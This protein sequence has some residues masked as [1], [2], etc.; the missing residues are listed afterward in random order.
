MQL[1]ANWPTQYPSEHPMPNVSVVIPTY[2]HADY[3]VEA[4]NSVLAQSY[5]DFEIVIVDDGSTDNTPNSVPQRH[6]QIRYLRQ[7]NQGLAAAR[8][9]GIR[10]AEGQII[11]ILDA[12][13]RLE[14]AFL[15]T[16]VHFLEETPEADAVYSGYRFVD[17]ENH[18]LPYSSIRTV[19]PARLFQTLIYG[20][21]LVPA[22]M[23]AYRRCYEAA[24]PFDTSC[25]A[26]ADWD[27][28]LRFA[29][30]FRVCGIPQKLVRY[31]VV[32]GSMSSDPE[33]MLRDRHTVLAKHLTGEES[34]DRN[35]AYGE[36][37][38][39]ATVEYLQ[40]RDLDSAFRRLQRLAQVAP[41]MLCTERVYYEL[42]SA[43]QPRGFTGDPRIL[44]L[45]RSRQILLELLDRLFISQGATKLRRAAFANAFFA[46]GK[47][48][49]AAGLIGESTRNLLRSVLAD[50]RMVRRGELLLT[51]L[52]CLFLLTIPE[53]RRRSIRSVPEVDWRTR[54]LP[55]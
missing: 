55:R 15:E 44:D 20:N 26:S 34:V 27:M 24:G 53:S 30:R 32:T 46:L 3:L 50:L 5:Q 41:D 25:T 43:G 14:P 31:R 18:E 36:T 33:R 38:L 51:L 11:S 28:W 19:P 16:L 45:Q 29:K 40:R 37:Y 39:R 54:Q 49:Y 48:N 52:K 4:I 9:N 1:A 47:L 6:A 12:D 22:C 10:A 35:R 17:E 2:N 7:E 23:V 21:F 42:A 13:D 8:N